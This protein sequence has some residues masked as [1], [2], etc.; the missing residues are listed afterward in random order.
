M[1]LERT[2]ARQR[3]AVPLPAWWRPSVLPGCVLWLDAIASPKTLSGTA[4]SSWGDLSDGAAH[5]VQGTG[6][7]QPALK[8]AD[9]AGR[10]CIEFDGTNDLMQTSNL[11]L[12]ATQA[13][14]LAVVLRNA[15]SSVDEVAVV[16]DGAGLTDYIALSCG[17]PAGT[18]GRTWIGESRGNVGPT[19]WAG[20]VTVA[21]TQGT[22]RLYV[23]EADKSRTTN[24]TTWR[25]DGVPTK[26]T[27]T[28][29]ANN[30]DTFVSAPLRVGGVAAASAPF[31]GCVG[32]VAMFSRLLA[33]TELALLEEFAALRYQRQ[34]GAWCEPL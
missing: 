29:N 30:A 8:P 27:S 21:S 33:P 24:E 23:V 22:T 11:D 34:G 25:L 10:P 16:F 4:V 5:A 26:S 18:S 7:N 13:A 1:R 28:V 14:T 15:R 31:S 19:A 32:L 17:T 12:S 3:G 9:L 2:I 6:A 20:S